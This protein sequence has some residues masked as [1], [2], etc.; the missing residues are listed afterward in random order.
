MAA[1]NFCR[2]SVEAFHQWPKAPERYAYLG[3][4]HRHVFHVEMRRPVGHANRDVEF[5]E[6][7]NWAVAKVNEQ[8]AQEVTLGWSC[9]H[10]GQ[11]MIENLDATV[12]IVSEDGENGAIVEKDGGKWTAGF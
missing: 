3:T 2:F 7:K 12:A 8:K 10:W 4:I 9:E 11:W 5:I 1:S 6:W